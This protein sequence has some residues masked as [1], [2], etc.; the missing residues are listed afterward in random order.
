MK[1]LLVA[2][3][4][5][6]RGDDAV[7]DA[8][9]ELIPPSPGLETLS[10]TQLTPELSAQIATYDLVVFVDADLLAQEV[11][12]A[13]VEPTPPPPSL[14][15]ISTPE[16]VVALARSLYAFTGRGLACRL[17]IT[18]LAPGEPLTPRARHSAAQAAVLLRQTL[19]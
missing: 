6:L 2:I 16:E 15:H 14:T 1:A 3:G 12:L 17:P 8:T 9:L 4:N 5:P 11:T 19:G 10:L 13:P 18:S 7:A